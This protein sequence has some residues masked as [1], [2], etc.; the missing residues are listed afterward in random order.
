MATTEMCVIHV[1]THKE[2]SPEWNFPCVSLPAPSDEFGND[3]IFSL[4][5][6]TKTKPTCMIQ[7]IEKYDS[8]LVF[9]LVQTF[10]LLT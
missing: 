4:M 2:S 7:T 3:Y 10:V 5:V 6:E 9:G 8:L 1:L